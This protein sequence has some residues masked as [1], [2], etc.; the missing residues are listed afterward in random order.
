MLRRRLSKVLPGLLALIVALLIE[1]FEPTPVSALRAR[2]FDTLQTLQPRTCHA[3]PVLLVDIDDASLQRLGQWPWPRARMAE[4]VQRIGA[5]GAVVIVLD[6][7]FSE[8]DRF[9]PQT[10]ARL[11]PES[12]SVSGGIPDFDQQLAQVI[13]AYPVVGAVALLSEANDDR[14]AVSA[15]F[16]VLGPNPRPY[17]PAFHGAL[18]NIPVLAEALSGVGTF[19]V[20]PGAGAIVRSVSLLQVLG[21]QRVPGLA[22]EAMRV[23]QGAGTLLLKTAAAG[24]QSIRAGRVTVPVGV[25]G[26]MRLHF[27]D[28]AIAT[29]SAADLF[30]PDAVDHGM[31][32]GRIVLVGSSAAGL[33]DFVTTPAGMLIPGMQVHAQAIEQMLQGWYLQRPWWA[34]GAER[35]GLLVAAVVLLLA[36]PRWGVIGAGALLVA[37][38]LAAITGSWWAFVHYRLLID[39]LIP[40]FGL[41]GV[42]LL[43][44]LFV[45][46]FA[47]RERAQVRRAFAQYLSPALV[48][49]L[50]DDPQRLRLGGESREL[51]FLFSD[52]AGF[53]ALTERTAPHQLVTLLNRY[54]DGACRVVM[55]HGG[56]IDKI[57]GDAIHAM[58]NAPLDQPDHAVRAVA[59]ALELDRF[60]QRF[61]ASA[62][63]REAGFGITRIGVN[64]GMAVVGNFGGDR[65]F[66]YTAHGDAINTAAR[67]EAANKS[68]G[69]RMCVAASTV[70]QC[71]DLMFRPVADLELRGKSVAVTVYEPFRIDDP[72][73]APVEEYLQAWTSLGVDRQQA[74]SAFQS[75]HHRFPDDPL[76]ALQLRRLAAPEWSAVIRP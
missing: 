16:A 32:A 62:G 1:W 22:I 28:C 3:G 35:L 64:T 27:S 4:L 23:A 73:L 70:G 12:A 5:A 52:I 45:Y 49:Q 57:V 8:P 9:S 72:E 14:P 13:S 76:P 66:D 47:E 55:A 51:S 2:Y 42:F 56:T 65:R 18:T 67:L 6:M 71:P 7:V 50:A 53:T 26:Q 39:P 36:L 37:I 61:R 38:V 41:L 46:L 33:G 40:G 17:L 19:S 34:S 63:A 31:L 48:R 43:Q 60:A 44:S 68:L 74:L 59:C 75:L 58:F 21:E 69:T 24:L 11:W 25:D 29:V 54:L 20:V 30:E 15:A 10:L